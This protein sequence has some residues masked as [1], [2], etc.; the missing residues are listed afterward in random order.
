MESS[1]LVYLPREL[2][3]LN[4][5]NEKFDHKFKHNE[6][7]SVFDFETLDGRINIEYKTREIS[8][9]QYSTTIIG[10][11]KIEEAY[12]SITAD[13]CKRFIF[14]FFFIPDRKYVYYEFA[15]N[16]LKKFRVSAIR[17]NK[18]LRPHFHIP[19]NILRP[20]EELNL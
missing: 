19:I 16:D 14:I 12:D 15:K 9:F 13:P 2:D 7:F 1:F 6:R 8:I 17:F 5:L 4:L 18:R 10:F 20:L 3:V 11:N